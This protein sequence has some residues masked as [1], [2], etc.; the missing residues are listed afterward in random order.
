[1]T[2]DDVLAEFRAAEALLEGHFI[3]SSGLRSSRYLQCARVLM[4]PRRGARL[5]EALVARIPE[6]LRASISAVVSPA[7]GG[8]ICGHEMARAL[9]VEAMFLERPDGVFELRRGFRLAP[10]QRVL[11][12]EDVVTTGLS[13][14]E[15]IAAIGRA[16][17]ETVAAAALVDR[18]NGAADLGVPFFPLI[19]L[20]VPTYAADA[21]PP[22]LAAIPAIKPGSR[23]VA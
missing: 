22:E 6:N 15:A 16:G 5:A 20:D 12:M 9:G 19:R 14:K 8:V 10:G 11:M 17:G 21:L 4:D 2:E 1:M 7:M 18:S 3:L 13:S 23:A